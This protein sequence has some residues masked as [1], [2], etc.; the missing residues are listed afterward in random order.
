MCDTN[1][2]WSNQR[3]HTSPEQLATGLTGHGVEGRKLLQVV[4]CWRQCQHCS[5]P[6]GQLILL[7]QHSHSV[8]SDTRLSQVDRVQVCSCSLLKGCRISDDLV[9]EKQEHNRKVKK[10]PL[11]VVHRGSNMD[12]RGVL[13]NLLVSTGDCL[14]TTCRMVLQVMWPTL[15][16]QLTTLD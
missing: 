10:T 5:Q 13:P 7:R 11:S 6:I 9:W 4:L 8:Q 14:E 3:P 12:L 15:D 2:T 1:G 16:T